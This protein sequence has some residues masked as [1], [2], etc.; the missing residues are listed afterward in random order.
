MDIAVIHTD[1]SENE[2]SIDLCCA[3]C[4]LT[5]YGWTEL[6]FNKLVNDYIRLGIAI[7]LPKDIS[8]A[9]DFKK[10]YAKNGA[11]SNNA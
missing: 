4:A 9:D 11:T 6:Q 2:I 3:P 1:G 5:S 10:W 8:T 7:K